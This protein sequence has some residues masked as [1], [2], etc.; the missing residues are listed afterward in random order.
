MKAGLQRRHS[1]ALS[2]EPI[3]SQVMGERRLD[4]LIQG[5]QENALI[6]L[7]ESPLHSLSQSAPRPPPVKGNGPSPPHQL[8]S[9]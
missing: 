7:N 1:R 3:L 5:D 6:P 9:L 4:W 2:S 8:L